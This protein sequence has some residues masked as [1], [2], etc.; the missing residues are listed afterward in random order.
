MGLKAFRRPVKKTRKISP[1]HRIDGGLE[2]AEAVFISRANEPQVRQRIQKKYGSLRSNL[3]R[4]TA[5]FIL[6]AGAFVYGNLSVHPHQFAVRPAPMVP[7]IEPPPVVNLAQIAPP[8][9]NDPAKF[10]L[11]DRPGDLRPFKK[12]TA[13]QTHTTVA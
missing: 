13:I 10:Y 8:E 6:C 7:V 9:W 3:V 5:G 2:E 12:L 11:V 4:A 1:L